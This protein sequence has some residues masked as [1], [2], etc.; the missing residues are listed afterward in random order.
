ME[1]YWDVYDP[2][3]N[4]TG[5]TIKRGEPFGANEFYVSCEIW[6]INSK[7]QLLVTRRH[8]RKKAGGLWEFTGGGVLAGETSRLA[9]CREAKEELGICLA[10]TELELLGVYKHKNYFMD[11]YVARKD[12]RDD[13]IILDENEV[14][15]WVWLSK[16]EVEQLIE[17]GEMV[18]SVGIRYQTFVS[19]LFN[20]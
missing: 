15:D 9:A 17:S 16:P 19:S 6:I 5:K 18:H 13:E 8:P 7:N 11:I 3:R 20:R 12:L 10:E 2:N 14:T 1:E 4:L